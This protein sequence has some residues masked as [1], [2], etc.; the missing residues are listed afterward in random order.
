MESHILQIIEQGDWSGWLMRAAVI[1]NLVCIIPST[2]KIW[3]SWSTDRMVQAR[4][5]YTVYCVLIR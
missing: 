2:C 4:L 3:D 1:L 5:C